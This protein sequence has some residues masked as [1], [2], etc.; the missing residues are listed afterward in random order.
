MIGF[1]RNSGARNGIGALLRGES[2]RRFPLPDGYSRASFGVVLGW[3]CMERIVPDMSQS[4]DT[5]RA[6]FRGKRPHPA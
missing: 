1:M 3:P 5:R 6:S 4:S 2:Q